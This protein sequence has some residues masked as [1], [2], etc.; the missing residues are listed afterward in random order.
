M[1]AK[2]RKIR[3]DIITHPRTAG[4]GAIGRDLLYQGIFANIAGLLERSLRSMA[5]TA[6]VDEAVVEAALAELQRRGLVQWWPE[7]EILWVIEA[8]DEQAQNAKAWMA[9]LG[10]VQPMPLV[11]RQ[12]FALSYHARARVPEHARRELQTM[13]ADTLP[14]TIEDIKQETVSDTI[15]PQE[16]GS[17]KQEQKQE[18]GGEPPDPPPPQALFDHDDLDDPEIRSV[19]QVTD[20]PPP[21]RVAVGVDQELAELGLRHGEFVGD[22]PTGAPRERVAAARPSIRDDHG[23]ANLRRELDARGFDGVLEV[24]RYGW[25]EVAAGR[26]EPKRVAF[27][28]A[29]SGGWFDKLVAERASALAAAERQAAV[30]EARSRASPAASPAGPLWDPDSTSTPAWARL[31]RPP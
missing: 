19:G 2:Y 9:V 4:I 23:R 27:A 8:A 25:G 14:D 15:C 10:E 1:G 3:T 11:V 28:F 12:S 17:R 7:L 24:M 26:W 21:V 30:V 31:E 13:L 6:G 5:R 16:A 18:H 22:V 29:K 20:P